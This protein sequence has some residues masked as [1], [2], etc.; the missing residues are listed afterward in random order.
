MGP[1]H[2]RGVPWAGLMRSCSPSLIQSDLLRFC[3]VAKTLNR[4][5]QSVTKNGRATLTADTSLRLPLSI[6]FST[7]HY[8]NLTSPPLAVKSRQSLLAPFLQPKTA[9]LK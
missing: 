1:I 3:N 9:V 7:T 2:R 4:A 6:A 5:E 8:T